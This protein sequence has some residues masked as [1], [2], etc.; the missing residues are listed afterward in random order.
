MFQ[1]PLSFILS[2]FTSG[3]SST[4]FPPL[5][6]IAES[7]SGRTLMALSNFNISLLSSSCFR[8]LPMFLGF[9]IRAAATGTVFENRERSR[10]ADAERIIG[11]RKSDMD[12][13][14]GFRTSI[15]IA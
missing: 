15:Y 8:N 13:G 4:H 10:M 2:G 3:F 12:S 9:G 11:G 6:A 14:E 1:L 5:D 7:G